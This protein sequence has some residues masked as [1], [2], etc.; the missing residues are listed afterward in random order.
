MLFGTAAADDDLDTGARDL[1][2]SVAVDSAAK[3]QRRK[4]GPRAHK[5]QLSENR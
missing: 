3:L 1:Y 4:V 5:H 2:D